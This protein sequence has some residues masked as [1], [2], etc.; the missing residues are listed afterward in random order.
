MPQLK[1]VVFYNGLLSEQGIQYRTEM[2]FVLIFRSLPNPYL[3]KDIRGSNKN[4]ENSERL[5]Q[6]P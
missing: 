1:V 6:R 3:Y 5:S 2:S 4:I